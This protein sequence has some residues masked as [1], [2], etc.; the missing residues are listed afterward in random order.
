MA[1]LNHVAIAVP[2]LE[3]AIQ[4]YEAMLGLSASDIQI[5]PEH[6]VRVAFL[7]L[8]NTAIELLEPYGEASPIAGFLTKNPKG[9]IHHVCVGDGQFDATVGR[10]KQAG[11]RLLAPP[12]EGAHGLPVVFCH[13]ADTN[14]VL[15]EIEQ[16]G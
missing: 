9:G 8:E 2:V 10:I 3:D 6:G 13:P 1:S 16:E 15:L 5:L 11:V 14:G 7:R 4:R 12:K